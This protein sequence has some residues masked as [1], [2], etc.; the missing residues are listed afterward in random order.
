MHRKIAMQC[1]TGRNSGS[2][3]EV[4]QLKSH[5]SFCRYYVTE[6]WVAKKL[7]VLVDVPEE[8]DLEWLRGS[9]PQPNDQLQ[10]EELASSSQ[11]GALG[12]LAPAAGTTCLAL[13][14]NPCAAGLHL[15]RLRVP[16]KVAAV[17]GADC[18]A[19]HHAP[20][21]VGEQ[22]RSWGT[23]AAPLCVAQPVQSQH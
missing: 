3:C 23:L 6:Q 10:P 22:S 21:R 18:F 1:S 14:H 20:G 5:L 9:G 13:N 15:A 12:T 19:I 4:T 7:E 2:T 17:A 8:V 11:A 16:S